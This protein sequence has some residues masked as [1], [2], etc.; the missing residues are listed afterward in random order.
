MAIA[1]E[2]TTRRVRLSLG[3]AVHDPSDP[4]GRLLVNVLA[5]SRIS[6]LT[7]SGCLDLQGMTDRAK[8]VSTRR[9]TGCATGRD[10]HS[11]PAFQAQ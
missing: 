6:R 3:G 4:V 9:S 11:V 7:S 8:A 10:R 5:M 1:D 2:L